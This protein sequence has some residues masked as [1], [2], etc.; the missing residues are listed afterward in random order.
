MGNVQPAHLVTY[1]AIG[2]IGTLIAA[3]IPKNATS[4]NIT[5][6]NHFIILIMLP[7]FIYTINILYQVR[8]SINIILKKD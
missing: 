3:A 5:L 2:T 4:P 1:I 8:K 6:N 7:A